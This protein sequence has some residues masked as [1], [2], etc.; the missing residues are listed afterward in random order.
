MCIK[1]VSSL[2]L[3]TCVVVCTSRQYNRRK[4]VIFR[5]AKLCLFLRYHLPVHYDGRFHLLRT[6]V[7]LAN[8]TICL[9]HKRAKYRHLF[10]F[11][12]LFL[13]G[14]TKI[15]IYTFRSSRSCYQTSF[16]QNRGLLLS[17]EI[18]VTSLKWQYHLFLVSP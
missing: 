16:F 11:L 3:L 12:F 4:F 9:F 14:R 8:I 2:Q 15:Y 17:L 1:N 10:L 6:S 7:R 13:I 5:L 18:I